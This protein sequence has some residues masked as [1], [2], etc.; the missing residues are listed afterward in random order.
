MT[1]EHTISRLSAF[2][3]AFVFTA[4]SVHALSDP[5]ANPYGN[6][7][8][9]V[10]LGPDSGSDSGDDSGPIRTLEQ[11]IIHSLIEEGKT[12]GGLDW[13]RRPLISNNLIK[14]ED[15]PEEI[16]VDPEFYR[17]TTPVVPQDPAPEVEVQVKTPIVPEE[18]DSESVIRKILIGGNPDLDDLLRIGKPDIPFT[19]EVPEEYF[20][21]PPVV[22][23]QVK[24]SPSADPAWWRTAEFNNQYALGMIGVE[25]RYAAGAT[26]K[27][28]LGAIYDSG[29]DLD[30]EDVGRIRLDLSHYYNSIRFF[31]NR[32]GDSR[33]Q[34][35]HG[36]AVYGIAGASR[37]GTGIHG[38]APDAQFMI[39][40]QRWLPTYNDFYDALGRVTRA[41]VDAMNNSWGWPEN[42]VDSTYTPEEL[43]TSFQRIGPVVT[44]QLRRTIKAGVSIVFA[45]GNEFKT[46]PQNFA[47]LPVAMP[48][49]EKIWIAV[50]A[51]NDA[52]DLTSPTLDKAPFANA[53]GVAMNWCL[54]APGVNITSLKLGGGTRNFGGTSAATPHVT[55]AILVLKSQFPEL[56]T[57]EIH[58]ILFDTA[59]DLGA[60]GVDAVFGHGA[61]NLGEALAPQGEMMVELG[62]QVNHETRPL[63]YS[64]LR[65]S[66]VTGGTFGTA[67]SDQDVLVTDRYYRG[68]FANLG[69]R[70]VSDSFIESP[71]MHAG[72]AAAFRAHVIRI[73]DWEMR[74]L[75]CGSMRLVPVMM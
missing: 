66:P 54:A 64:F 24:P 25:H 9:G 48:E 67:L 69:P 52:G 58:K 3:L 70:I 38:V 31:S 59:V 6:R 57:P 10:E 32:I 40:K 4:S 33:N 42:I 11:Q 1:I 28:T 23:P 8:L 61:L 53:C 29:I 30:H 12:P 15:P 20:I 34:N 5:A 60:P 35:G 22:V 16:L 55:G 17:P 43:L 27:G 37:N 49:L 46:Q 45:T 71:E 44:E 13:L 41:G 50:T 21:N 18:P 14:V 51:L 7:I 73:P 62:E 68:Y 56:S 63:S 47:A 65:E 72:L 2:A 26:G 36:T 74:D 75:I 39:L 19:T